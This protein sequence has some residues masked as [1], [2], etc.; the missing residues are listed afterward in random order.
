MQT[1]KTNYINQTE[2]PPKKCIQSTN[3]PTGFL[4]TLF[5]GNFRQ[6]MWIHG[7]SWFFMGFHGFS[8]A[9]MGLHGFSWIFR[10]LQVIS[11][12]VLFFE[13]KTTSLFRKQNAFW[14]WKPVD[15][16][17]Q[18]RVQKLRT[19]TPTFFQKSLGSPA[20]SFVNTKWVL[21]SKTFEIQNWA[22]QSIDVEQ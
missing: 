6:I 4:E 2:K 22:V 10:G 14:F 17:T 5:S 20:Q 3:R 8:W 13:N 1:I 21:Q 18:V 9:F 7:P 19:E 16:R 11:C 12:D 15:W